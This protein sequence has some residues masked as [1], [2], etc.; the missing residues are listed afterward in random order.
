MSRNLGKLEE[1]EVGAV[2]RVDKGLPRGADGRQTKW[3]CHQ[4]LV[5]NR[6]TKDRYGQ[7]IL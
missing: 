7:L 3:H 5:V 4:I 2:E 1:I 6:A